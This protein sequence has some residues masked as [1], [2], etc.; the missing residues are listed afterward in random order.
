MNFVD[1][2]SPDAPTGQEPTSHPSQSRGSQ[3]SRIQTP[4]PQ[5][6]GRDA[7]SNTAEVP[8]EIPDTPQDFDWDDFERRFE[9]ALRDA[10]ENEKQI[11]KEVET[12][13]AS[14][15]AW[16]SAASARDDERAAK[17]LQTR[18][19]FVNMSEEK[20]EQKQRH[21]T[22]VVQAFENALALLKS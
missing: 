1:A 22:Q 11:L 17:R 6:D 9:Q 12:M 19:R 3:P 21:Y 2:R 7:P 10:D 14:F 16:A 4:E 20:M 8:V 18:R 13:S 5:R 15:R